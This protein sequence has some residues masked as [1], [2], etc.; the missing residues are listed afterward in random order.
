M[1]TVRQICRR[2][3]RTEGFTT[4]ALESSGRRLPQPPWICQVNNHDVRDNG[5]GPRTP[6]LP[7]RPGFGGDSSTVRTQRAWTT[8]CHPERSEERAKSR[9]LARPSAVRR[10]SH[11]LR[12]P[13]SGKRRGGAPSTRSLTCRA[14]PCP[15]PS[16]ATWGR[17]KAASSVTPAMARRGRPMPTQL[18]TCPD[19]P[20]ALLAT[21]S[22]AAFRTASVSESDPESLANP[23]Y[24]GPPVVTVAG[25]FCGG[26]FHDWLR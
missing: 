12:I 24:G 3:F 2:I 8:P 15:M 14:P 22:I 11:D 17:H 16:R 25:Q 10:P 19:P 9:D 7:A 6:I 13:D 18:A 21:V 20:V 26:A 23:G 5:P 1:L 4:A